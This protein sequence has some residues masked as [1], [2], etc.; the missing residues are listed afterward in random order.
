MFK[1]I[2]S[3][4]DFKSQLYIEMVKIKDFISY[5]K[6]LKSRKWLDVLGFFYYNCNDYFMHKHMYVCLCCIYYQK[7]M[8]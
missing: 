5:F 3:S 1:T 4:F 2:Y 6:L 7:D 8:L